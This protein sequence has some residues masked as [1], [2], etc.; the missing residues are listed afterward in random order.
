MWNE[1]KI[2][3]LIDPLISGTGLQGEIVRCIHV[4]LLC[5][6][7]YA[8]DRPNTSVILS[9]L[10]GDTMDLPSPKPPA[11]M[12]RQIHTDSGSSQ[13]AEETSSTN[14]VTNTTLTVR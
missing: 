14:Y 10:I 8:K 7:E 12:T 11:F 9:M 4:G 1:D 5:V 3:S 6:Q 13:T 2:L